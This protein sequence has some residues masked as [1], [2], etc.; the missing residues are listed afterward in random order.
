MNNVK[1][2]SLGNLWNLPL[3]KIQLADEDLST[4]LKASDLA[5]ENNSDWSAEL[6]GEI[7]QGKQIKFDFPKS[8]DIEPIANEYIKKEFDLEGSLYVREAWM[9]SQLA[10]DYNPVHAHESMLSGIIYLKVPPQ[11][12]QSFN[13]VKPNGAN[14]LDGCIHF[15]FDTYHRPSLRAL[16]P[17]AVLPEPGDLYLFP[18]Y[19][20]HTVYPFKGDGERRCIAFNMDLK[21]G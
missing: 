8:F 4:L 10:G 2:I 7:T 3:L 19:I 9:V 15:I 18:S 21:N 20:L 17:R 12:K 13:T 5:F 1:S 14:C 6:A 16:G 11:I